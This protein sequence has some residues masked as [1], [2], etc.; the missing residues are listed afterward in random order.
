MAEAAEIY[1]AM[2]TSPDF[3]EFLT[4]VA[5][6]Y[7][8][9]P[10]LRN[11]YY[12]VVIAGLMRMNVNLNPEQERIVKDELRSG[13][14]RT[15]EDVIAQALDALRE[16]RRLPSPDDN[17]RYGRAVREML[18]FVEQNRTSSGGVSVKQLIHEGHRL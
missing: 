2:M 4:V 13:H 10:G 18:D 9:Q 8:D 17:G 6:D 16:K 5:Y 3:A 11:C 7:I 15:A 14:F 12:L 1:T